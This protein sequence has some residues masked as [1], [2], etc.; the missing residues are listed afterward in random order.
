[1]LLTPPSFEKSRLSMYKA[2]RQRAEREKTGYGKGVPGVK[3]DRDA[4]R[5]SR[6]RRTDNMLRNQS[7]GSSTAG[8]C[9]TRAK[10]ADY[11]AGQD[12][13]HAPRTNSENC[14][15]K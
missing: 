13:R 10:P 6:R 15:V 12:E 9:P 14:S 5:R 2:A 11:R 4:A 8:W 7:R 1:M 3:T